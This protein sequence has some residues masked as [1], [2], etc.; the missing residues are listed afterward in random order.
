MNSS[1]SQWK[2][3]TQPSIVSYNGAVL[4]ALVYEIYDN[5]Q[6][7]FLDSFIILYR[8]HIDIEKSSHLWWGRKYEKL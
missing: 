2:C 8:G 3:N 7:L 6:A 4:L 1:E 5:Y